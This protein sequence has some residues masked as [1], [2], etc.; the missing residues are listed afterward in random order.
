MSVEFYSWRSVH[1]TKDSNPC[2]AWMTELGCSSSSERGCRASLP[3]FSV[4][5]YKLGLARESVFPSGLAVP[6]TLAQQASRRASRL[7]HRVQCLYHRY[8]WYPCRWM[9][10]QWAKDLEHRLGLTRLERFGSEDEGIESRRSFWL[11]R[12]Y[13]TVWAFAC[14]PV[15]VE[16]GSERLRRCR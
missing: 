1:I 13:S 3:A 12:Y 8:L 2:G 7:H 9:K 10:G 15:R 14:I 5:S 16:W 4:S 11:V 6:S